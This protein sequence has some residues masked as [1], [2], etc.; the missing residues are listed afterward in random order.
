M[1]NNCH[2]CLVN[3]LRGLGG[4]EFW[5]LN[6]ALG[7]H[8][9]GIRASLVVQPDSALVDLARDHGVD[10]TAIPIRFDGAPW[11]L[12]RL[13]RYFRHAG[14]TALV[15]NLTKDLKAAG[16][17]GLWAGVPIR[18]AS[19]ESDFPLKNKRY[20]RW[21]FDRVATG[22]L[23][24]SQATR[25]TV[26]QSAPWLDPA[27]VHLLYKGI[28]LDRFSPGP[29]DPAQKPPVVGFVGELSGRKGLDALM[30]A[31]QRIDATDWAE[32][33]ELRLAGEGPYRPRLLG[34]RE[35]LRRPEAVVLSGFVTDVP[36]F[37]R[38]CRLAVLPS[39][40]E[41]FGLAAAEASAC[42][43]PVVAARASSLPE[44]VRHDSTGLLV[45]PDDPAALSAAIERL[46]R[47]SDLAATLGAAG[48]THV[49]AHFDHERCLD[50][51]I[52]LVCPKEPP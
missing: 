14:V 13:V 47:E 40:V 37:W 2:V 12:Y 29:G 20:Y 1:F 9:R 50:Q 51:L 27:R 34:W 6:A 33:P 16:L 32:P 38:A 10:T 23:V 36:A 21:Y 48:R 45:P 52:T 15:C 35:G 19:R 31:W 43:L 42:G 44:L 24:N 25:R 39:R 18:L 5:F 7:L 28:D 8:A 4:A 22:V 26:L 41:G 49:S 3:S 11:T 46:L 17:A 30:A